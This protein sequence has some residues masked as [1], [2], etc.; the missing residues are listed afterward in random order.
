MPS[1]TYIQRRRQLTTYFDHT[2]TAA[3]RALTSN[4]PVSRVRATVRAGRD[5]MRDTLLSWLPE[6]L[7]GHTLLDAGCGTGALA[8]RAARQG[9]SVVAVDMAGSLIEVAKRR[10]GR[11]F[12]DADIDF[13]VGD[14]LS[15]AIDAVDHVVAMDSLIH[16]RLEDVLR[17]VS[18]FASRARRSVLF[19]S[20]PWT[21][22]L[23]AMHF[24]GRLIPHRSHRAPAIEP[25]HTDE[26]LGALNAALG[27]DGWT[28]GRTHRVTSGFYISQAIEL[29]RSCAD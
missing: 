28:T 9:G 23:G 5:E 7:S 10:T 4:D 6:D 3:W 8:L 22:A 21:P 11:E 20:A 13:R 16:Y 24:V 18:C 27:P 19:T 12:P 26:L 25:V 15:D 14:M 2:A 1:A 29:R 17:V